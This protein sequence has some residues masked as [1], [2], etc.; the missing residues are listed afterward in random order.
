MSD[1]ADYGG[2]DG[3]ILT[4]V[5]EVQ[6]DA[7]A[8]TAASLACVR[9]AV[10]LEEDLKNGGPFSELK[11]AVEADAGDIVT[12]LANVKLGDT[13]ALL[14]LKA[15]AFSV[16]YLREYII[17]VVDRAHRASTSLREDGE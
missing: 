17:G 7:A 14:T 5:P 13:D 11:A 12:E 3:S 15:K 16:N 9:Q 4:P 8:A 6:D 10:L 1:L 2:E